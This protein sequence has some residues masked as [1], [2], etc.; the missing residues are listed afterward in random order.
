MAANDKYLLYCPKNSLCVIDADGHEIL[1]VE[2]KFAVYDMCWSSYKNR[3]L[4]LNT[5]QLYSLNRKTKEYKSALDFDKKM[6]SC[7][8]YG[9][10]LLVSRYD[11]NTTEAYKMK[12]W[13]LT[14][15]FNPDDLQDEDQDI[16]RIRYHSDGNYLGLL[17]KG[18]HS[19]YSFELRD[20]DD[21]EMLFHRV[22]LDCRCSCDI[23][24]LPD[25]QRLISLSKKKKC[26][27]IDT[28]DELKETITYS[29]EVRSI[30]FIGNNKKLSRYTDK[31][32]C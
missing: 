25:E 26:V 12:N 23:V 17:V 10:T 18:R 21:M 29:K 27:L 14:K 16:R 1:D 15:K 31:G 8:C 4:I 32:T 2:R 13:K 22:D 11:S 19:N 6:Y 20:A 24:S 9:N 28:D 5:K 30:A 7:T 3:F